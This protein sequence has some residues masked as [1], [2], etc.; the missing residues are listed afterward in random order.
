MSRKER[1]RLN[2]TITSLAAT[3]SLLDLKFASER[4]FTEPSGQSFSVSVVYTTSCL[5]STV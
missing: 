5:F 2:Q 4:S 3:I 1:E